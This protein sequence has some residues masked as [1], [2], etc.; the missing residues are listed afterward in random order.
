MSS[1]YNRGK[2]VQPSSSTDWLYNSVDKANPILKLSN[3]QLTSSLGTSLMSLANF[4]S[5]GSYNWSTS[6][7]LPNRPVVIIPGAGDRL[8]NVLEPMQ[9]IKNERLQIADENRHH[10]PDYPLEALFRAVQIC[11]PQFDFS[12]VQFVTDRNNLRKMLNYVEGKSLDESFRIDFQ[13]VGNMVVLMRNDERVSM[14]CND[15]GKDFERNYTESL[16]NQGS[17][18]Y[19]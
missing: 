19:V 2:R 14:P 1:Y 3:G 12:A 8:N 9:L 17:I 10:Q 5:V 7:S 11:S 13:R 18:T 4:K 6:D 15:Y 16:L